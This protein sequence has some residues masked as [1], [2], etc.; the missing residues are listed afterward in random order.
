MTTLTALKAGAGRI[1]ER[2][3][4]STIARSMARLGQL[5]AR[6][7]MFWKV[8]YALL[9]LGIAGYLLTLYILP[10]IRDYNQFKLFNFDYGILL[11]SS[12]LL[13][14]P[15][16]S[17]MRVRGDYIWADNQD[18][19]QWFFAIFHRFPVAHYSLLVVHS[20]AILGCSAF[21]YLFLRR[22]GRYSA[23]AVAL[24]VA[25]SPVLANM[26]MDLFH[27][28]AFATLFILLFYWAAKTGRRFAFYLCLLLALSCKEDVALTTGFFMT[29]A[30]V[31]AKRFDLKRKHFVI[32]FVLSV[33]VFFI[34]MKIVLPYYKL[35]TCLWMNPEFS[36]GQLDSGPASP[37]FRGVLEN[38]HRPAFIKEA[39]WNPTVGIYVA[40]ITWPLL[41]FV[42]WWT[43]L[44]LLPAAGLFVNI[45]TKN[46]Y[47]LEAYYHYDHSTMAGVI[48]AV[49]EG[50]GRARYRKVTCTVLLALMIATNYWGY[51]VRVPVHAAAT[52]EFYDMQKYPEVVFLEELNKTL[53]RDTVISADYKSLCYLVEGHPEC[54]MF[55]N[56]F[57]RNYFGLY[58]LC[59]EMVSPPAVDIVVLAPFQR[60]PES[61]QN[62]LTAEF[63]LLPVVGAPVKIWVNCRLDEKSSK[64]EDLFSLAEALNQ[65]ALGRDEIIARRRNLVRNGDFESV[66]Q[67]RPAAW[68]TA[69]WEA[70][71]AKSVFSV[72]VQHRKAGLFSALV[73]NQGPCDSRWLQKVGVEPQTRYRIAG[74]IRT[75]GVGNIGGG[76]RL[77]AEGADIK[78]EALYGSND[79]TFVEATGLTKPGQGEVNVLCRIGDYGRPNIGTASFDRVEFKDVSGIHE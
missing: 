76:A 17:F 51:K 64:V 21:C 27:T 44:V 2:I 52:K 46:G 55:T 28:E 58:G 38:W 6:P 40:R 70:P 56:P 23:L 69:E 9:L 50:V 41:L 74:W 10:P 59:E 60:V 63:R 35:Q 14:T 13:S 45:I 54:F 48:I 24:A 73:E 22:Y 67:G 62:K 37:F 25:A 57:E 31:A 19:F 4:S 36:S 3:A 34:N 53:P 75:E 65:K 26:N 39:F 15:Y 49:L 42:R 78:T 61:V 79:W 47:Q 72:D 29:L 8:T 77:E 71:G 33:A 32:G 5:I 12:Y 1:R 16:E 66:D 43:P 68:Q 11:H 20:L 18:Y 30:F 7:K